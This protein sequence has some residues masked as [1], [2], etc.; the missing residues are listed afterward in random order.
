MAVSEKKTPINVR[1]KRGKAQKEQR[2]LLTVH[3]QNK[4]KLEE[5]KDY[6][7][8]RRVTGRAAETSLSELIKKKKGR[9]PALSGLES[10]PPE[11]I[12]QIFLDCL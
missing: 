1:R 3:K 4:R 7:K 11:L 8:R 5:L 10:L 6:L 2:S 9:S 12:E